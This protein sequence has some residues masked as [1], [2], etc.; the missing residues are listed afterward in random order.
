MTAV[1]GV[2][3]CRRGWVAVERA[4]D[5]R[6]SAALVERLDDLFSRLRAGELAAMAVDM[7]IGLLDDQPRDC[8]VAARRIL[9]PRR[10]S[11]FP[12]PV[13]AVL[14][15]DDYE[16]ACA[17]SRRAS[18]KALSKQAFNLV[19]KIAELDRLVEPADQDRLVE[20]HPE[21]S[22][23][24]LA[25]SPPA[26]PKRTGPGRTERRRLLAGHDPG[27]ERLMESAAGLPVLDLIDAAALVVTAG[28]VAAGTEQRLGEQVDRRGLR[29]QV[30]Y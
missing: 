8:D 20:A 27:L 30:V 24:R 6:Y 9:G 17:I 18:G 25:G 19:P 23:A 1:I 5:G 13:R 28:H 14:E 7:P 3:G 10:A 12:A 11:V 2:D 15:A 29:A 22:F 21:C 26:H 16:D 4:A